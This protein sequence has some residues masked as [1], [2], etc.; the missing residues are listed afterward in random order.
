MSA[1][2]T[3]PQINAKDAML[4]FLSLRSKPLQWLGKPVK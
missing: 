1:D 3:Q 4:H 2:K